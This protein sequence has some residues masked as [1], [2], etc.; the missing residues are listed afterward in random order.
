MACC[1]HLL[2]AP[3]RVPAKDMSQPIQS[4][5]NVKTSNTTDEGKPVLKLQYGT[6]DGIFGGAWFPITSPKLDEPRQG[7]AMVVRGNGNR[8]GRAFLFIRNAAGAGYRSVDLRAHYANTNWHEVVLTAEDFVVDPEAKPEAVKDLPKTPDWATIARMDF[9]AVNLEAEPAL[10]IREI[11]ILTGETPVKPAAA[12]A[13][14]APDP[15][16][17]KQGEG[18]DPL[19]PAVKDYT[20]PQGH[21]LE[22]HDKF[23][24]IAK[25][26]DVDLL[27]L[28]D[29][30]TDFWS[31]QKATYRKL[32]PDIKSANFGIGGDGTQNLLWR[33]ENGELDGIS[34]KV[35]VVLIGTN[36]AP[37]HSVDRTAAAIEKIVQT[38]RTKSPTTKVL[39]MGLFPRADLPAGN[40]GPQNIKAIN[41]LISKLDDSQNVRY[42]DITSKL[43]NPDGTILQ[44][45]YSDKVHLSA[46][47][48]TIWA[49][50]IKPLLAEMMK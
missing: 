33:L 15:R 6:E 14:K 28:G 9:S 49:E 43:S 2:A 1:N 29:S 50:S 27:W 37:W 35:A 4:Y 45:A 38:I 13:V 47:G 44:E 12:E 23:V 36:N 40:P 16:L 7:I 32:F 34:P 42:L 17:P 10:E 31:Q 19:T 41:A 5:G 21:W 48:F 3:D 11:S 24:A 20:F 26:G 8:P 25:Q 46:K 30:I 18:H 39:L 22:R